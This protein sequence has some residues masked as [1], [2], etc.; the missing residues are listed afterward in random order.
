MATFIKDIPEED[1]HTLLAEL[2]RRP[3][4]NN[5][6]RRTS[7]A[8]RSQALGV[9]KR[10]AYRPWVSRITWMYPELWELIL[11][12]AA[13]HITT[14]WTAVQV[15]ESYQSKPHKDVGNCGESS[16]VAFGDYTGGELVVENEPINIRHRLHTFNGSQ[17]LHWNNPIVGKKYSL[18]FFNWEYPA[19]WPA[20]NG[21]PTVS[22]TRIN[23]ETWVE[24]HDIDGAIYQLRGRKQIVV[25]PPQTPVARVGKVVG[26]GGKAILTGT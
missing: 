8:G 1:F 3:I 5:P 2:Q 11:A 12:F 15:N 17:L 26:K 25:R 6:D 23:E 20:S 9:I 13:K 24:V 4:L 14:P 7:G 10:W 19:W 16:I 18:V 21:L 22:T